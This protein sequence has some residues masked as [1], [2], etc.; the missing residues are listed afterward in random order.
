MDILKSKL[1]YDPE[2]GYF[3]WIG[4]RRGRPSKNNFAGNI[5]PDG[6]VQI[7]VL[8]KR[9]YAHRLAWYFVHG[10]WP[11]G[12]IDHKNHN[13][14]D[15][16]ILNLRDVSHKVNTINRKTCQKNNTHGSIGLTYNKQRQKWYATFC[17]KH[18]GSFEKGEDALKAYLKAKKEYI[19]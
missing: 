3:Q 1:T 2:T 12:D 14:S 4:T 19:I 7:E 17:G 8:G 9:Y 13:K 10:V 5:K 15:N 16:R 6:Y 18:L 11:N